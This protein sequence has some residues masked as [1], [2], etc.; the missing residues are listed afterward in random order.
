MYANNASSRPP[1]GSTCLSFDDA[2]NIAIVSICIFSINSSSFFF[3]SLLY[4]SSWRGTQ[5]HKHAP[6]QIVA[7][8]LVQVCRCDSMASINRPFPI[9]Y[10]LA[11]FHFVCSAIFFTSNGSFFLLSSFSIR[12]CFRIWTKIHRFLRHIFGI[13]LTIRIL[14][15]L[16]SNEM[17]IDIS[18]C[19]AFSS[20]RTD[21]SLFSK[22]T[23]SF[24]HLSI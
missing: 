17:E 11:I 1:P 13:L 4:L 2:N 14:Y 16:A 20:G 18:S 21:N 10:W 3:S 23:F 15:L 24:R 19:L 8:Q 6:T 9:L 22:S 12:Y 7:L 5:T